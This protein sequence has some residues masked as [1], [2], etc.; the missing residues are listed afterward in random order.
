[1]SL[2]SLSH[3]NP[4]RMDCEIL[5]RKILTS[6]VKQKGQNCQFKHSVDF[7]P[8]FESLYPSSKSL[9]KQVQRAIKEMNLPKDYQGY[10]IINR[11]LEELS[12]ETHLF[13]FFQYESLKIRV[14]NNDELLLFSQDTTIYSYSMTKLKQ[15]FSYLD[16]NTSWVISEK[17]IQLITKDIELVQAKLNKLGIS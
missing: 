5:I 14:V 17:G 15:L 8:F 16:I 9:G 6:E 2:S 12:L 1:M 7:L 11:S 10:Y 4:S 13:H 3:C